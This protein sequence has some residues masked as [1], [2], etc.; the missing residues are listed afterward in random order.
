MNKQSNKIFYDSIFNIIKLIYDII[1][2]LPLSI[3]YK[4]YL[5]KTLKDIINELQLLFND[6][7]W[8]YFNNEFKIECLNYNIK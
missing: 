7:L 1:K 6:L 8:E 2:Q 4:N 5:L 3:N